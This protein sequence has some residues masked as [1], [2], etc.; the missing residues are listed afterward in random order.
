MARPVVTCVDRGQSERVRLARAP[1]QPPL[2]EPD[3]CPSA[4][5]LYLLLGRRT[6]GGPPTAEAGVPHERGHRRQRRGS[7]AATRRGGPGED[8]SSDASPRRRDLGQ[9]RCAMTTTTKTTSTQA[10]D[11]CD[12]AERGE[13]CRACRSAASAL[14]SFV[15]RR[16]SA[17]SRPALWAAACGGRPRAGSDATVTGE[18]TAPWLEAVPTPTSS[19]WP[20]RTA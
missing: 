19:A 17:N 14:V 15:V 5:H 16:L 8:T 1:A 6:A 20:G 9:R 13:A 4:A 11:R 2:A 18:P 12:G 3:P 7:V 10:P